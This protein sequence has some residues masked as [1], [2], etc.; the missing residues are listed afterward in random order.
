[1]RRPIKGIIKGLYE[2]IDPGY[3][4]N[5][6]IT[7]IANAKSESSLSNLKTK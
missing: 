4:N 2:F 5:E 7:I 6:A 1:M 3:N